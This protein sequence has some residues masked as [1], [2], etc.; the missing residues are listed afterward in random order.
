MKEFKVL[1]NQQYLYGIEVI[2]RG[3]PESGS[4][5]F[6]VG[7]HIG[8]EGSYGGLSW[9]SFIFQEGESITKFDL[10]SGAWMD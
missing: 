3:M 2:Y 7:E 9:E 10:R 1:T 5:S 8:R 6:K 4:A